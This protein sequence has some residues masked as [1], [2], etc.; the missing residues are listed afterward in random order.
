MSNIGLGL[1]KRSWGG[2]CKGMEIIKQAGR[3]VRRHFIVWGT[4]AAA[5]MFLGMQESTTPIQHDTPA[6]G[7]YADVLSK[8]TCKDTKEGVFPTGAIVREI[9]GGFF[10]TKNPAMIGK[11]LDEQFAGKDWHGYE[12]R[13]FCR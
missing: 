12:V 9:G 4:L 6:V 11:A 8:N 1:D 3:N 7:T 10:F 5:V 2:Y 13:N